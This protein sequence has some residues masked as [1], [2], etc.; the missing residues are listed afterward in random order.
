MKSYFVKYKIVSV[1]RQGFTPQVIDSG[2]V[3]LSTSITPT[4][5]KTFTD[6]VR[7]K[8]KDLIENQGGYVVIDDITVL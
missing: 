1:E 7:K 2:S 8:K 5:I 6:D 4:S 3:V